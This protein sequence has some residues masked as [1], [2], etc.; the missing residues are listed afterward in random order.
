MPKYYIVNN[1]SRAAMYGIGTYVK[2]LTECIQ[3]I[4]PQYDLCLLDLYSEVREFTIEKD[5]DGISHYKIPPFQGR[6]NMFPYYRS[7][8]FLLDSYIAKEEENIFHFNYSQHFDL[9]RLIKE[10]Y[11]HSR[12]FY[13]VHY[14]N[15]CFTLNGNLTRFRRLINNEVD[16]PIRKTIQE[17][18]LYDRRLFSLCD[19]IIVLSKFTY[20]LLSDDY[21]VDESRVH[22]VYNGMKEMA[23][24]VHSCNERKAQEEILFVGRLDEIKGIE[25]IIRAFKELSTRVENI[26]LTLIGDGDFSRYLTICD[27]IWDKVTFTGKLPK[28][29]LEPFF[30]RATIGIQP[31]FHEQCSYSAIE[32]MAHGVPFIAS[33]STGLGEM[34][35]YTP[36]CLVHIDEEN[37]QPDTFVELL[38]EKMGK[39]LKDKQLRAQISERLLKLFQER[40]SLKCMKESLKKIWI[41]KED[42]ADGLSANFLHHLDEEVIR[43]VRKKPNLDM[44]FLGLTGIGC[45]LFWRIEAFARTNKTTNVSEYVKLQE[46]LT[47]YM[48]WVSETLKE[49]GRSAFSPTFEPRPLNWLLNGLIGAG[50]YE[51]K[52]NEVTH[53]ISSLGV[54]LGAHE[55]GDLDGSKIARTALGIYNLNL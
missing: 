35:D 10:K 11:F 17:E 38:T 22:T 47:Y 27:G 14:L 51:S 29:K 45:Y 50:F 13:T 46:Y 52:V 3:S 25:Y 6:G 4:L 8:L 55:N 54:N 48:D 30:C 12:I 26:H 36:E 32:M 15:W 42:K 7:V 40:Y 21:K 44:D 18:F 31:S 19:E 53:R 9:I 20:H 43:I 28:E 2:Q 39:L 1:A 37:F 41:T 23:T 33:D 49:D 24:L 34:M 5:K 16:D